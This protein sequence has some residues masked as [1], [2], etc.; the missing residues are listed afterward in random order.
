M[1]SPSQTVRTRIESVDVVRGLIMVI[2]ALDH[3]RDYFGM[4]GSNPIDLASTSPALF[5]TRWI[6]H[7]CAPTFFLLTGTGAYLSLSKQTP[8][9][10]SRFLFT[11]GLWLIFLEIVVL[12]FMMQFNVDYRVTMLTV[13]WALGWSMITLS[14]LVFLRPSIVAAFGMMLI[15]GH[16]LFDGIRSA[17]PIWTFLHSPGFLLNNPE[18]TVF[19]SYPI[20]PWI[21]VTAVGYALG[22]VYAWP[23]E[24]RRQWLLRAGIGVTAAFFVLRGINIYGDPAKW[25]VQKSAV[26]TLISFFNLNKYPPSLLFLLMTLGPVLL[27]LRAV[28]GKTP[29]VLRPA[30]I[31]G[32]VPMFYFLLHFPLIHLI[33]VA[34]CYA[35]NGSAHWM[36]E[37]PSLDK[38]PFTTPPVWGFSL[39][40]VYLVWATVV[41]ACYPLSRWYADVKRRRTDLWWLSYL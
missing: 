1:T 6:T 3:T 32:K 35:L 36:F 5:F 4:P 2:M 21:G 41:I 18:H 12:R 13:L 33:A 14:A 27:F 38:F 31:I 23:A 37:S 34:V 9:Q 39:P 25:A 10:L 24:R 29:S 8:R 16:N 40:I 26:F 11:R 22:Q 28:D 15:V 19:I 7:F 17:N 30:M 20:I